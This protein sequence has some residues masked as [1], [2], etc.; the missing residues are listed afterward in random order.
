M[1]QY[2]TGS[3]GP[4]LKKDIVNKLLREED[5]L[6]VIICTPILSMGVDMTGK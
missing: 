2:M 3:T 6:K 1:I 4:A 5:D